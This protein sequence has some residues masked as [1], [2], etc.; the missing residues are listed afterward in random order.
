VPNVPITMTSGFRRAVIAAVAS[1]L[2]LAA[3]TLTPSVSQADDSKTLTVVGTSDVFDS[4][5]IQAV[6]KP[7][8]EAANP[9]TTFNYV[10]KG[11]GAA[12]TFAEAG[13]ASAL[14]VHAASLENQF[15]ADGYSYERYG[16]AIFWGDYVLAGPKAD[17]DAVKS[18][19]QHD[20]VAAFEKVA[21]AGANGT[22][23]FVSRGGTPGTTVQEHA[24][25]AQTT[26]VT[27]CTV[28]DAN[29]GGETPSTTTGACPATVTPPAWY[30]S[31]GLTQGP[32]IQAA[33]TCNFTGGGC[34]VFTDRGTF[35][36]LQTQ[37]GAAG[38]GNSLA[39]LVRDNSTT[40]TGGNTLLV[41]SFHAY[42]INP[43]RFTGSTRAGINNALA[44]KF[45]N[46]VTS[47]TEQAKIGNYL[48]GS[49]DAPF[50]PDAAPTVTANQPPKVVATGKSFTISGSITNVVPGTPALDDVTVQ[51]LRLPTDTP[52]AS[53]TA[54]ASALTDSTGTYHLTYKPTHQAKY[55]VSVPGMTKLEN[56]TLSP[57]FGDELHAIIKPLTTTSH[58]SSTVTSVT[59]TSKSG[60]VTFKG[61]LAPTVIGSKAHLSLYA[62]RTST[63]SKTLKYIGQ[64]K[65]KSGAKTFTAKFTLSKHSWKTQLKYVN[66]GIVDSGLSSVKTVS[67]H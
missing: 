29:G 37:A 47:P 8:F 52:T 28:S 38:I 43:A 22:A 40:A 20:I 25:W 6:I 50:R 45:L 2:A 12:I 35:Q 10:S 13:T 41:N 34:Y 18:A 48:N 64:V 27:L 54:V 16:R 58:V 19:D 42:A 1:S 5:L 46:F 33:D 63:G 60:V 59:A 15:V 23:N 7:D 17:P 31:T 66:V 62:V 57:V 55:Y 56:T 39:I 3:V 61:K 26:G 21:A 67:V 9:G 44:V 36:Y 4:N 32:N 11:T 30:H 65:L 53:P 49:N 14:L 24:I 51:L